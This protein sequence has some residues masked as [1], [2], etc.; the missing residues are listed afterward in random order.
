MARTVR[1]VTLETRAA[2]ARLNARPEPYWRSIDQGAHLG[3]RKGARS[4]TWCARLYTDGRYHKATLGKADDVTDADGVAILSYHQAQDKARP[5]FAKLARRAA[6]LEP[7]AA[8]PY[9]VGDATRDYLAWYRDHRKA[10][11]A[12]ETTVNAHI[13]P[14]FGKTEVARLTTAAIGK[15]LTGLANAPARLR[16]RKGKPIKHRAAPAD[17][18]AK[19][20][21]KATANRILSIL[22]AALNH[23]WREGKVASDDAWRRVRPFHNVDAPVVRYLSTAESLRLINACPADFRPM[24]KA[25][26]LTGCRYGELT[27]LTVA[28]FNADVGT[29]TVR[30][31]KSGK[32]RHVVLA[33]EGQRFFSIATAGKSSSGFIL[34]RANGEPWGTSHQKRPMA[35]AC[36]AARII[37][38]IS[39]HVLRHS[40]ASALA[41][42]GVPLA[43]VAKQLGHSDTRMTEKHYAHLAPSYLAEAIR[44]GFPTL[45]I[46]EEDKVTPLAKSR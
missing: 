46:I 20:C 32:A 39:F 30:T 13:L 27:A 37:P 43:V 6:G 19:R 44:A 36:R 38:A 26:L 1:D 16:S 14:A 5:W 8:G 45:G 25:A 18:D 10:L 3:Y 17:A 24:V 2:R 21:R 34:V 4:G 22:K 29:L 35:D 31:S 40:H 23:A 33:D 12:T 15:W 28:D 41:M 42:A 9:S 11:V 7:A